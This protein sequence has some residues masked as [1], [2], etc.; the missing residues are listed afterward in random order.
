M[1]MFSSLHTRCLPSA[2]GPAIYWPVRVIFTQIKT[3]FKDLS[4][5]DLAH[6]G[7]WK[8]HADRRITGPSPGATP[9]T[10]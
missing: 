10:L 6:S 3:Q 5:A 7:K 4:A 9:W 1:S 2:T 8:A